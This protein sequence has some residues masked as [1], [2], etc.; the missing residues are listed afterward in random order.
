VAFN[1]Y[2]MFVFGHKF[3]LDVE[4]DAWIRERCGHMSILD[5]GW[6]E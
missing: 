2:Q 4:Y 3:K 5:D 6:L 1:T